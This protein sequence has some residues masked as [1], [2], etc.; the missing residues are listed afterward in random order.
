M[1]RYRPNTKAVIVGI[2][3][4]LIGINYYSFYCYEKK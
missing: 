1:K 4:M 3:L 2:V